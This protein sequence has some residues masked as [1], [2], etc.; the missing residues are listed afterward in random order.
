MSIPSGFKTKEE[1][2]TYQK[3]YRLRKKAELEQ[4]RDRKKFLEFE[5]N[6]LNKMVEH[7]L[8]NQ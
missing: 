4:L 3:E 8:G 2:N 7:L 6:R 1:W 5:V